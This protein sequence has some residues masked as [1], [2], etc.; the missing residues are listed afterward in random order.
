MPKPRVLIIAAPFGFGPPAKS[1]ILARSLEGVAEVSFSADR[2]AHD[3]I[4]RYK[5]TEARCV[6]GP[7]S[8]TFH[9]RDSLANFDYAISVNHFPAVQHL[10]RLGLASRTIFHDSLLSW[11][12][13]ES[14]APIPPRLL[15]YLVQDYPGA[16]D[17]VD[18]RAAGFVALTAPLM[19][20]L[21]QDLPECPRRDVVLHLGGM[22]SPLAEWDD[23]AEPI[24][25]L[26]SHI[27]QVLSQHGLSL[28]VIGSAHLKTLSLADE[29]VNVLGDASPETTTRLIARSRLLVTTPGIGAVYEAMAN[30]TPLVLLP[31]MNSAQLHHYL[32]FTRHDVPGVMP[33]RIVSQ[34]AERAGKLNWEQQ[35]RLCLHLLQAPA[36]SLSTGLPAF[37]KSALA[38]NSSGRPLQ[39]QRLLFGTLSKSSTID[40]VKDLLSSNRTAIQ[41][42][43]GE[44]DKALVGQPGLEKYLHLLPKVELHVHLEGSIRPELLLGLADRNKIALPFSDSDQFYERCTFGKF[45][46][47]ANILLM[48]VGCLRRLED[49]FDV[50]IDIGAGLANQNVRYA[51]IT[52]TPQF[53]LKREFPLD[54]ILG[55]LN[56]ARREVKARSGPDLRWIPDLV[57]SY[58]APASA[59]AQW[60]ASR[61]TA[62]VVALG[63]GGPEA[64]HPA[65]GFATQFE[66]AHSLGLPA[67]P[68]AGE[69]AGPE[70]IWQTI[71]HLRPSRIGH[72]VRAIED[73][74][75]VSYLA[76]EAMPLEVCLTSN[77]KLG[78]YPSYAEHPVKRLVDAGC[79]ISLNS[80]DPV[81]FQ[82]TLTNEYVHAVLDCGL[83]IQD[84]KNTIINSVRSSYRSAEEKQFMQNEFEH[85]FAKLDRLFHGSHA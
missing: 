81:F 34:L 68:H 12:T 35:T 52:W 39:A 72:G 27:S 73:E 48:G 79:T 5:P 64:G 82:T 18:R 69:G 25:K 36:A 66:H 59:I 51:E 45:R 9:D 11:R 32:V 85:E 55:T 14:K 28:A 30:D 10:A 37:V 41:D 70:S 67:N 21:A 54:N 1:L 62:G 84:I 80:D 53:Y 8:R 13:A 2:D 6:R 56:E 61:Q 16:A 58:P 49:F 23:I 19:W 75:L 74:H 76:R 24:G 42:R 29:N 47:F 33:P 17:L 44:P 46:D 22:T 15:A 7:F 78:V 77:V 20:P 4:A 57:R 50:V 38:G 40:I 31:P 3:F 60:A 83:A 26:V 63:L 65:S 71:E 43:T